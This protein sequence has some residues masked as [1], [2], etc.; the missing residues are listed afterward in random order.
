MDEHSRRYL[1]CRNA[2]WR[3]SVDGL[4]TIAERISRLGRMISAHT[5]ATMR[6]ARRRL[7]AR[8][9]ERFRISNWCL[10]KT[11][12]ATTARAPP[13]PASRAT[14]ARRWRNRTTKSR[15]AHRKQAG[16]IHEI[17]KNFEFASHTMLAECDG[18]TVRVLLDAAPT[19]ADCVFVDP[20]AEAPRAVAIERL[21]RTRAGYSP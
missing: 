16:E 14:V 6:S 20:G 2:R 17:L 15:I 1:R 18:A 9:R 12:S 8:R 5:P 7:G 11:D 13:G 4:R 3:K 10:T 19:Q 21:L